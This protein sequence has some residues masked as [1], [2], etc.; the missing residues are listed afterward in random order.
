MTIQLVAP[1]QAL[2]K[3]AQ[4]AV[5]AAL[6][7]GM[8]K[9][10]CLV[11]PVRAM[12]QPTL[13][14]VGAGM[15]GSAGGDFDACARAI[16]IAVDEA[17]RS[18]GT[19]IQETAVSYSGPGL[20]SRIIQGRARVRGPEIGVRD[21][22]SA[23]AAGL[24]AAP[25]PGQCA[26]HVVPLFYSVDGGAPVVDPR[27]LKGADLFVEAC[28][29]TA[30]A[31][32]IE[33]L[34]ACV[35]AAILAPKEIVAA[36]YAAALAVTTEEERADGVLVLDL[37]AG[38][39]GIACLS[40]EG[41]VLAEQIPIGGAR[42]TKALAKKIGAT[43]A[44]A[45]RAKML[46]GVVG[47]A[48]DPREA[49]EAPRVGKDGR[50]EANLVQRGD[51]CDALGPRFQEILMTARARVA[52]ARLAPH[53]VPKRAVLTGGGALIGGAREVGAEALGMPVRI[54][55]PIGVMEEASRAG[56]AFA[57]ASGLLRW[58]LEQPADAA[59]SCAY[60]P[61]VREIGAAACAAASRAWSWLKENF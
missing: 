16:R 41:L 40:P 18:A 3:P 10:V 11:A 42:L 17:E 30:P 36:P 44:A 26:L 23:L 5:A 9:T 33:A 54:G 49:L 12:A 15:Q 20:A 32:A 29:V 50:L 38:G 34:R 60:E 56:P 48:F 61:G 45:E 28:L 24:Q 47:G 51:F 39:A 7:V 21:V 6:D 2:K 4:S 35:R 53:R 55:R 14:L 22:Q 8:S 59:E 46:Y 43:F 1:E 52:D 37:G 13:D 27:G 58:R 25:S 57:A 31:E 19:P